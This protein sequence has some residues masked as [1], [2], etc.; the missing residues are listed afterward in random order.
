MYALY[1][2]LSPEATTVDV[3]ILGLPTAEKVPVT[4]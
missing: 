1:P 2:P 3:V 4:R